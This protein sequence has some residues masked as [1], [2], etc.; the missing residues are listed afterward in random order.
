M[1]KNLASCF[2]LAASIADVATHGTNLFYYYTQWT[3]I[4]TNIYFVVY[5][6][7]CTIFIN[8][9]S[10]PVVSMRPTMLLDMKNKSTD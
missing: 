10:T 5:F 2:L 6:V 4:L 8:R 9:V 1:L 3:L 7:S